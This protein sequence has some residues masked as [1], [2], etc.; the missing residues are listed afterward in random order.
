MKNTEER[1]KDIKFTIRRTN[2]QVG[3]L[4]THFGKKKKD[5]SKI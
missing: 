3:S 1:I 2:A 4:N 5:G